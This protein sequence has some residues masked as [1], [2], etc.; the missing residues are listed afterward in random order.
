MPAFG[1][2]DDAIRVCGPDEGLWIPV[3]LG[4]VQPEQ[5][6]SASGTLNAVQQVANAVG[7]ALISTVYLAVAAAGTAGQAVTA[8]LL[9]VLA[10]TGLSLLTLPLLPRRAAAS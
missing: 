5:A 10:I 9:I 3:A 8:N 4:D 2:L 7:A 1:G 6:G